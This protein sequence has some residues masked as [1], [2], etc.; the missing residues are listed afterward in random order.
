MFNRYHHGL[1]KLVVY[2]NWTAVLKPQ[3]Y[4]L[5]GQRW[6]KLGSCWT[7]SS[8]SVPETNIMTGVMEKYWDKKP[9]PLTLPSM[10]RLL[11]VVSAHL[12]LPERVEP[13]LLWC[14]KLLFASSRHRGSIISFGYCKRESLLLFLVGFIAVVEV[15]HASVTCDFDDIWAFNVSFLQFADCCFSCIVI[16]ELTFF[17]AT[18]R[19]VQPLSLLS[20]LACSRHHSCFSLQ[21]IMFPVVRSVFPARFPRSCWRYFPLHA[22]FSTH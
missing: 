4:A 7:S 2:K 16:R 17:L 13:E 11:S 6:Q 3:M 5:S 20:C 14:S 21:R 18:S 12:S 9:F 22:T 10:G 8:W 15:M 1:R 19:I